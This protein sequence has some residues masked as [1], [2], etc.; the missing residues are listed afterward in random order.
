MSLQH[1][2]EVRTNKNLS[3]IADEPGAYSLGEAKGGEIIKET[4]QISAVNVSFDS[5]YQQKIGFDE[6][7]ALQIG[8]I[9]PCTIPSLAHPASLSPIPLQFLTALSM[10]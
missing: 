2:L 9:F 6:E 4:V 8:E 7:P 1:W 3:V 10:N 5:C